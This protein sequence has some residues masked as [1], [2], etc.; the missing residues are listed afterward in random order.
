MSAPSLLLPEQFSP[1][2]WGGKERQW[3]PGTG[4][5]GPGWV[6][7]ARA[8]AQAEGGLGQKELP[9]AQGKLVKRKE[10]VHPGTKSPTVVTSR[11]QLGWLGEGT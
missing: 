5:E 7:R 9:K 10:N 4:M 8:Q 1:K 2:A 3:G 6:C 11:Q